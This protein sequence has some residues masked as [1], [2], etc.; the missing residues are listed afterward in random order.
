MIT[1]IIDVISAVLYTLVRYYVYDMG[2]KSFFVSLPA[3]SVLNLNKSI[4]YLWNQQR[5]RMFFL[6]ILRKGFLSIGKIHLDIWLQWFV[7]VLAWTA[8]DA[9]CFRFCFSSLDHVGFS[10][11]SSK[12]SAGIWLHLTLT[13]K[14]LNRIEMIWQN[15]F[16]TLYNYIRMQ[17]SEIQKIMGT[18]YELHLKNE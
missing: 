3:W 13:S 2:V 15:A 4:N 14:H 5:N 11:L 17:K 1:L 6:N 12:I 16:V 18:M 8:L 10:T 7:N 9:S